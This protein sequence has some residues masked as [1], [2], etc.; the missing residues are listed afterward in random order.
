[1][2]KGERTVKHVTISM[3]IDLIES[4]KDAIKT[5]KLK[6]YRNHHQFCQEAARLRFQQLMG[7]NINQVDTRQFLE[8]LARI[9]KD[10]EIKDHIDETT[11]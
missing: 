9:A 2:K 11:K 4:I 3:P 10:I 7:I 1:M 8:I 6:G 5:G